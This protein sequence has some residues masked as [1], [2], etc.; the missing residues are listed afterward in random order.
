MLGLDAEH[1]KPDVNTDAVAMYLKSRISR[2][3]GQWLYPAADTRPPICSDYIGQTAVS[4]CARFQLYAAKMD[5]G[6]LRSGDS[7]C[8]IVAGESAIHKQ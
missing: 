5:R 8:R 6:R 4:L 7:T 3:D 1:Y 2:S